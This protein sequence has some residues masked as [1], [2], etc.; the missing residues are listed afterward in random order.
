MTFR[1]GGVSEGVFESLNLGLDVGDRDENVAE[2]YRRICSELGIPMDK[3]CV[4]HQEH[5]DKVLRVDEGAGFESPFSG[6]D[7]FMTDKVGIPLVVRYA[8]CQGVLYYDPV[9][10][11]VAAVHSGWRGNT[12]NIIGKA[13]SQMVREYSCDPADILVGV[14]PSLCGKCAEF[15]D[16]YRELPEFMHKYIGGGGG[17]GGASNRHVDL[18]QCAF[19]QLVDAGVLPSHIEMLRRCTLCENDQF[20]SFRGA[21]NEGFEKSGHMAGVVMI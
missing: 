15:S 6:I 19:D 9:K 14:G 7:G 4:A 16:P 11:V 10:N 8:D 21:K 13:V 5:T 20:F 2:N 3:L 18:W 12:K 1:H 17:D